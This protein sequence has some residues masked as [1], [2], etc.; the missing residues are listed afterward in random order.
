[1]IFGSLLPGSPKPSQRQGP[2]KLNL[3]VQKWAGKATE[4]FLNGEK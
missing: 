2:A 1:M 3:A 4:A